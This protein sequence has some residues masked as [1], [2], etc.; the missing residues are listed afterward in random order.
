MVPLPDSSEIRINS[1]EFQVKISPE[2]YS[3]SI[4]QSG[5]DTGDIDVTSSEKALLNINK[6]LRDSIDSNLKNPLILEIY[7]DITSEMIYSGSILPG[8]EL[9]T[10]ITKKIGVYR[11]TIRDSTGISGELT[12]VVQS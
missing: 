1:E 9:P 12:F 5:S 6:V 7:D 2:Y 3:L 8:T 11:M 10:N 4:A